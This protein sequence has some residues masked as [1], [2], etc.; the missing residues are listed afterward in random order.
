MFEL[1]LSAGQACK[2]DAL[3][4]IQLALSQERPNAVGRYGNL[5]K[6][7]PFVSSFFLLAVYIF[8]SLDDSSR[9]TAN[10]AVIN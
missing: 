3:V 5:V 1:I 2:A 7:V 6:Q 10:Q 9:N 4:R 8:I